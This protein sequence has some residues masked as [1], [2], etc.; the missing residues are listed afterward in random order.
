MF[1]LFKRMDAERVVNPKSVPVTAKSG[2]PT[3]TQAEPTAGA[4]SS[5]AANIL[6]LQRRIGN[7]SVMR[8]LADRLSSSADAGATIQRITRAEI[9]VMQG[10]PPYKDGLTLAV[11][12]AEAVNLKPY[13]GL[14][15]GQISGGGVFTNSEGY[16]PQQDDQGNPVTY[17]EYDIQRYKGRNRGPERII[18]GSDGSTYYTSN[19]YRDPQRFI[20]S[21]PAAAQS[22]SDDGS[23]PTTNSSAPT[24]SAADGSD[25]ST[26]TS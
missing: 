16:Y 24:D 6:G 18:V 9:P 8:L 5:N 4:Q 20:S 12:I 15:V 19:H 13:N 11:I 21:Q 3:E 25:A 23:A 22:T 14:Q 7:Q 26:A 2:R 10:D 1:K 17:Q